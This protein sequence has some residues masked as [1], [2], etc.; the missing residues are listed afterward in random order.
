MEEKNKKQIQNDEDEELEAEE[1][2][3]YD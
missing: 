1:Y 2:F 3:R